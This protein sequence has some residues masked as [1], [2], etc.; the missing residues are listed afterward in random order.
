MGELL[1]FV[2]TI[3]EVVGEKRL[4][5]LKSQILNGGDRGEIKVRAIMGEYTATNSTTDLNESID[6]IRYL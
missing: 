6:L 5:K 1:V 3:A 4:K 2:D